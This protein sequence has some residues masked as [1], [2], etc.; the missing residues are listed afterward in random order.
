M[1]KVVAMRRTAEQPYNAFDEYERLMSYLL[2]LIKP[3]DQSIKDI[4]QAASY[5]LPQASK[6][7]D[8]AFKN[9]NTN[10]H[11][12]THA[13]E[14]CTESSKLYEFD[15]GTDEDQDDYDEVAGEKWFR[16]EVAKRIALLL[17]SFPN[18]GSVP[19]PKVYT[20]MLIEEVIAA[21]PCLEAVE[22]ACREIRR[23][24]TFVPAIAEFVKLLKKHEDRW[25]DM[26]HAVS[27]LPG[28][29]A[30]MKRLRD[31]LEEATR[32]G[33]KRHTALRKG[34]RVT[35]WKFGPG[36]V[37]NTAAQRRMK[38]IAVVEFDEPVGRYGT[39]ILEA[40]LEP[41]PAA[42]EHKPVQTVVLDVP[43]RTSLARLPPL[44]YL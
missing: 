4:D 27:F 25:A 10:G 5:S 7:A 13:V 28:R 33:V 8:A 18:T 44:S 38:S 22:S 42:L 31:D 14:K 29:Y 17:G 43:A 21:E 3:A 41:E 32:A 34:D 37:E 6:I 39:T 40:V 1:S 19:D 16:A 2:S 36:T 9:F 30:E 23:T 12:P 20:R 26:R 35:H 11:F 24:S 15:D